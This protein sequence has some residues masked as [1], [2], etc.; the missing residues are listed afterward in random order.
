MSN[1]SYCRFENTN[2]DLGDC[3]EHILDHLDSNYEGPA[4]VS[5]VEKCMEILE[6][7]GFEVTTADGDFVNRQ[8]IKDAIEEHASNGQD[9][10]DEEEGA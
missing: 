4:R 9:E 7:L 8:V 10:D 6:A 2:S 3:A 5:L 1:M